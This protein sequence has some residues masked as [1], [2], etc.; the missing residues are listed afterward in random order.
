MRE[1]IAVF[2]GVLSISLTAANAAAADA[3]PSLPGPPP[4]AGT[5]FPLPPAPTTVPVA[6]P[7]GPPTSIPARVATPGLLSGTARLSGRQVTLAIACP[8]D[9]S[10][11]IAAS[12]IRK[13]IIA[14][15]SYRCIA[16]RASARFSLRPADAHRVAQLGSTLAQVTIGRGRAVG[17]FAVT[18]GTRPVGPTFWTDG[19]MEC[20]LLGGYVPYVVA[21]NFTVNPPAL[22]DVRP[23]VA[24]YT[25][26]S[27]WQWLGTSGLGRSQWYRW[28]AG[29]DG[30]LQWKTPTGAVNPWTWAPIRAPAGQHMY[31]IAA[32]EVIYWYF[33]PRYLWRLA[34]SAPTTSTTGTY[35]SYP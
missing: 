35:C 7:T 34:P 21:P 25:N 31:A 20:S 24:F 3:V 9:G 23:W 32:F 14:R 27:G 26:A 28:S 11:S 5:G 16:R 15:T 19:G 2:A 4:P 10:A 12:A 8:S 6:G 30:I 17:Q 18:L 1:R 22:I 29:A 13:G 33:H